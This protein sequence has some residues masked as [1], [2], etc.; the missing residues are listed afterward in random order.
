MEIANIFQS[1]LFFTNVSLS[2]AINEVPY[3]PGYLGLF[4]EGSEGRARRARHRDPLN[5]MSNLSREEFVRRVEEFRARFNAGE[6]LSFEEMGRELE[7]DPAE[8][9]VRFTV[10]AFYDSLKSS[11]SDRPKT[12]L[13]DQHAD[14]RVD[15]LRRRH[16]AGEK[17]TFQQMGRALRMNPTELKERFAALAERLGFHEGGRLH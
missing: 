8:L 11:S 3:Q 12:K 17:L 7:M 14:R 16:N 2:A 6:Q 10:S 9:K 1:D 15:N 13:S 5:A 4:E